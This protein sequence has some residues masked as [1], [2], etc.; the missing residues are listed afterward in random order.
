M[1]GGAL[2]IAAL[3]AVTLLLSAC[4]SRLPPRDPGDPLLEPHPSPEALEALALAHRGLP[5]THRG[6]IPPK[7]SWTSRTHEPP[8][9][10]WTV[11]SGVNVRVNQDA[12]GRDQNE[13]VLS[14][15]PTTGSNLVGGANDYRTGSVKCGFYASQDGGATWTDGV[16]PETTYAFQGDPTAAHCADGSAVYVCLSFNGAFQPHGLFFYRSTSGGQTWTGPTTILNRPTGFPFADKEWVQCDRTPGSPYANRIYVS[17]TDFGINGSPILLRYSANNGTTWSGN[18]RV[19]DGAGTQGSV[20][21]VGPDGA[22]NV[23]WDNG[24]NLGFDRSTNGGQT[25]GTDKFPSS[26]VDISADP[27]FRRNSFPTMDVD[28]SE[29]PYKGTIYIAWS[30]ARNGDPDILLV[31]S[32]DNGQTWS[33][34]L[35]VN[36]DAVGN[37]ADQFFPWLA[38]DP[39]GRV[40]VTFFDRR[41]SPGGRPYEIWGAIS[42]DGGVTF[43]TNF[44]ISDTPSDGSLNGF[45]GDYSGLAATATHLHPLWT[46]LRAG[47]GETDAYT[48]RFPNAFRYDEVRGVLWLDRTTLDFAPQDARFGVDLDYDVL[49]GF[50]S[51]LRSDGGFARASCAANDWGAPPYVDARVPPDDDGYWFLVRATGPA[52]IGTYGDGSPA[53]PN[54]RD[55]LDEA[56]PGCP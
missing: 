30:D 45:V 27:V 20:I 47:T 13:T 48:D 35:R 7:E 39:L 53:R 10:P 29:G 11:A 38:V 23:A 32:T 1:R 44:L 50:L 55:A 24:P 26:V 6:E 12:S 49:S 17:W 51:E 52:G 4:A 40:A 28:R 36:D 15:S 33:A 31:R 37:G 54:V 46:D 21:A 3:A 19:S 9:A 14:A 2:R 42:R 8:S 43:D 5:E 56:G 41:R 25:F 34:P 18:V 16:L 22:V